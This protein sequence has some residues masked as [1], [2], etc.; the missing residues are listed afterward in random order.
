MQRFA[1]EEGRARRRRWGIE[2]S[3]H[4]VIAR[5]WGGCAR[6]LGS[7][8]SCHDLAAFGRLVLGRPCASARPCA[9]PQGRGALS[10][11]HPPHSHAGDCVAHCPVIRGARTA[12]LLGFAGEGGG[13]GGGDAGLGAV[14]FGTNAGYGID[15]FSG[16]LD[17]PML[18]V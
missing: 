16:G 10:E 11:G 13:G 2:A 15:F 6:G 12:Y 1:G 17:G 18:V 14:G 3:R 5:R 7:C 4:R 9:R 8:Y